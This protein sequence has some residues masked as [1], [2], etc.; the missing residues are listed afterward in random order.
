MRLKKRG[1]KVLGVDFNPMAI[2]RW[3]DLGLETEFG[4]ASDPEFVA[5]LPLHKAE[6]I[7]STVP[8]HPTGLSHEDTRS[9]LIQLTRTAG[10]RGRIAVASHHASDTEELFAS[11]A[12]LVLEPFQD[13][14]DRAVD[15]LCG[16]PEEERT[17]IP[18]IQSEEKQ[19][20]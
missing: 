16:A 1:I 5:D 12:D 17:D 9:T 4:D 20:S 6:W 3:R 19:A 15:L 8:I 14:A 18:P 7:V 11:G 2:R 13:A 10:F